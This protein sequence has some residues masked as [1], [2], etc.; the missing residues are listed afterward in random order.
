MFWFFQ[1]LACFGGAG[2]LIK[3]LQCFLL[4]VHVKNIVGLY[5]FL[6]SKKVV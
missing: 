6:E 2:Y 1:T 3:A 5:V 4:Q